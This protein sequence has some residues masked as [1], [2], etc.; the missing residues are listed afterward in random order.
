MTEQ[1]RNEN[2]SKISADLGKLF[3][4]GEDLTVRE[5]VDSAKEFNKRYLGKGFPRVVCFSLNEIRNFLCVV[6]AALPN[7]PSTKKAIAFVFGISQKRPDTYRYNKPTIMM[8]GTEFEEDAVQGRVTKIVNQVTEIFEKEVPIPGQH[9][10][11]TPGG[12]TTKAYDVGS[13]YP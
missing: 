6:D 8:V 11:P 3:F 10:T 2:A 1:E 4:F 7:V 9:P 12:T 5:A 13:I